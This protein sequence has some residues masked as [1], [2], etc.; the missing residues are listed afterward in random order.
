[1]ELFAN[2]PESTL[3]GSITNS[4]T[5][6]AVASA[7][8]FPT[9]GT[10]RI[11][12]GDELM[13]VT[14]V[15]GTTFT[16]TRGA[17]GTTA[18]SHTSGV[19]VSGVLTAGALAQYRADIVQ[20][21]A[22]GSRPSAGNAGT[23]YLTDGAISRDNGSAW[24]DYGPVRQLTPPGTYS[25]WGYG[26]SSTL[27]SVT[28]WGP[29]YF[30]MTQ[31]SGEGSQ[32]K[33]QTYVR[34]MPTTSD[35]TITARIAASISGATAF[36]GICFRDSGKVY[37]LVYLTSLVSTVST[38][39]IAVYNHATESGTTGTE[40]FRYTTYMTQDVWLRLRHTGTTLSSSISLDGV[41]FSSL[42]S[43]T[44]SGFTPT[45][46][47]IVSGSATSISYGTQMTVYDWKET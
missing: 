13:V 22:I 42:A 15:S 46:G 47:G 14:A 1:M 8:T 18:T 44:T 35:I 34:N 12:I 29:G 16:V 21:G 41:T 43:A 11:A 39:S 17:E 2:K 36:T 20:A 4:A 27:G 5:T 45:Q 7:S 25:G 3:A 38:P 32:H 30:N 24:V 6:L 26:R 28:S 10:F 19:T 31:N 9:G 23:L 40:L 33:L 37:S